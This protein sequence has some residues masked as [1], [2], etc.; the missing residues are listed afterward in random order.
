MKWPYNK[1]SSKNNLRKYM[2][3]VNL[4]VVT[5]T[6]AKERLSVAKADAEHLIEGKAACWGH[7]VSDQMRKDL[8]G[9]CAAAHARI[10][11]SE[12]PAVLVRETGEALEE[13]TPK[14]VAVVQA[15]DREALRETARHCLSR[16]DGAGAW[17]EHHFD[18]LADSGWKMRVMR[19]V[20]WIATKVFRNK[21]TAAELAHAIVEG[22]SLWPQSLAVMRA[23][24]QAER[25]LKE[26]SL[27]DIT[28][29]EGTP[30]IFNDKIG[31]FN[32]DPKKA[33]KKLG[34]VVVVKNGSQEVVRATLV[35]N[36][37]NAKKQLSQYAGQR[38]SLLVRGE[39][40]KEI[41]GIGI[42][43]VKNS[44][45]PANRVLDDKYGFHVYANAYG[46]HGIGSSDY[47][48]SK[49]AGNLA[50]DTLMVAG[51]EV[52]SFIRYAILGRMTEEN[53]VEVAKGK[54]RDVVKMAVAQQVHER[55]KAEP[56]LTL[57]QLAIQSQQQP[58]EQVFMTLGLVTPDLFRTLADTF[59]GTHMSEQK[60]LECQ[61]AAF[62]E[63]AKS[64]MQ[65][66]IGEH[67][68]AVDLQPICLNYGVNSFA[69]GD[70]KV[71]GLNLG[72]WKLG[73]WLQDRA[74][75]KGLEGLKRQVERVRESGKMTPEIESLW[76]DIEQL[77]VT[78]T[79]HL[80]VQNAYAIGGRLMALGTELKRAKCPMAVGVHCMSGKDRTGMQLAWTKAL[81]IYREEEGSYPTDI[82]IRDD[83][84][85]K[86]RMLELYVGIA[87][88][89][90]SLE[91]IGKNSQGQ[92]YK[93]QEEVAKLFP[94]DAFWEEVENQ[95]K[96]EHILGFSPTNKA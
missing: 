2:T 24:N 19:V 94:D 78:S 36:K 60:M 73:S 43:G 96:F 95:L 37:K 93:V 21:Q 84:R 9:I 40:E 56:G 27:S 65:L 41:R 46:E 26:L 29:K 70:M 89:D 25:Y 72:R 38:M 48:G 5:P 74:N 83:K 4:N 69:A 13:A 76:K 57:Q 63:L 11:G 22:K 34:K 35:S 1:I 90:G 7:L 23:Y 80:E 16:V 91:W 87:L 79:S 30:G 6:T 31:Q 52:S 71:M 62:E 28:P 42:E 61:F 58:V 81:Q 82:E 49:R 51:R 45:L 59:L 33:L 54:I 55:L 75:R 50:L 86:R 18:A 88:Q 15:F 8:E 17:V 66:E 44:I 14:L 85:I 10:N 68:V 53:P 39:I 32:T 92:G 67:M 47:R 77:T 64:P 12:L 3:P 20:D